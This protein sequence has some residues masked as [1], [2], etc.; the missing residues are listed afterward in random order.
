MIFEIL[1]LLIIACL[2]YDNYRL[3]DKINNALSE[4]KSRNGNTDN[5]ATFYIDPN[6]TAEESKEFFAKVDEELASY[7]QSVLDEEVAE[8]IRKEVQ[9]I[10]DATLRRNKS[11]AENAAK[12]PVEELS[13][14]AQAE[15]DKMAEEFAEQVNAANGYNYEEELRKA[16]DRGLLVSQPPIVK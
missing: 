8:A 9:R 13:P 3:R 5:H 14:E 1:I 11:I 4:I 12:W 2:A 10:N 6:M 16:L 15:Y 7:R